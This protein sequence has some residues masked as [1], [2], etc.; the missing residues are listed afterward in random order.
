MCYPKLHSLELWFHKILQKIKERRVSP[1]STIYCLFYAILDIYK[2]WPKAL[3]SPAVKKKISWINLDFPTLSLP[4]GFC[5]SI[6][7]IVV[8]TLTSM[9]TL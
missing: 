3:R 4:V 1:P 8:Y 5:G 2:A 7:F 9:A 6:V